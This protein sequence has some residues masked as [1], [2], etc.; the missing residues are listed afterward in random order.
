[1]TLRPR[2]PAVVA[3]AL[4]TFVGW[5]GFPALRDELRRPLRAVTP[6]ETLDDWL[7]FTELL[8]PASDVRKWLAALPGRERILYVSKDESAT[9]T[10]YE[11]S[12]LAWP[13]EVRWLACPPSGKPVTWVV[14]GD[15]P[16]LPW[17]VYDGLPAPRRF[18]R[19]GD[20]GPAFEVV[21]SP[22]ELPWNSYCSP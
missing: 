22:S 1:M 11:L 16:R 19:R 9:L 5:T 12:I 2:F 14:P 15:A 10:F 21:A 6:E 17:L 20:I 8:H 3:A 18:A 7:A 4:L 13:R